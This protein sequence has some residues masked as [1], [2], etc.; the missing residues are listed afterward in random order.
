[1]RVL[2]D[3]RKLNK[4]LKQKS[5]PIPEI[6]DL[7]QTLTGFQWPAALDLSQGYYHIT[8]DEISQKRCT[9][10]M[11]WG[12]YHYTKLPVGVKVAVDTFQEVMNKLFAG[13]D[14][15]CV[16]LNDVLI[17]SNG[18]L[19]DH[20]IVGRCKVWRYGRNVIK[21]LLPDGRD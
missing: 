20:M 17:I 5:F 6:K 13:L 14:F 15:V 7:F 11:P 10:M 19:E 3:F 16:N 2:T 4:C 8:L 9:F 18:T 1:V 21:I 12:N